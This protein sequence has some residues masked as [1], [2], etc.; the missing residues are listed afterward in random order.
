MNSVN[1]YAEFDAASLWLM[2]P[3]TLKEKEDFGSLV[4][5]VKYGFGTFV[6]FMKDLHAKTPSV[7][8][9]VSS[10]S[11]TVTYQIEETM[12][13]EGEDVSVTDSVEILLQ[14]HAFDTSENADIKGFAITA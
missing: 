6:H 13:L 14:M 4:F 9:D 10:G 7:T 2:D 3:A 1:Q 11:A 12:N 8:I 5:N